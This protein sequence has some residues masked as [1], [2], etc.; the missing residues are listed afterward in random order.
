MKQKINTHTHTH[1]HTHREAK[2]RRCPPKGEDILDDTSE[3]QF[4]KYKR[5]ET[6]VHTEISHLV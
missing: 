6:K 1:V 4:R 3:K 5:Y 2:T